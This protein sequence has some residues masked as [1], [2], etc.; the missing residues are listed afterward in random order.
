VAVNDPPLVVP[1][2]FDLLGN[3]ELRVDMTAG[4]TPHTSETTT[5]PNPVKGVLDNDGD[6]EGD[7]FA[8]TGISNCLVA[9]TTRPLTARSLAAPS[10]TSRLPASSVT[11]RRRV[12]PAAASPIR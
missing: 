10:S 8:V 3:T 1:E 7:L 6:L 12:R 4:T 2:T 5:N 11:R 9:D